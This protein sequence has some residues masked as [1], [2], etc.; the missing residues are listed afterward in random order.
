MNRRSVGRIAEYQFAGRTYSA[1]MCHVLTIEVV[2][3]QSKGKYKKHFH[4][5]TVKLKAFWG[6]TI[7]KS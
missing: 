2:T 5:I 6:A 1:V 3:F 4:V 7:K